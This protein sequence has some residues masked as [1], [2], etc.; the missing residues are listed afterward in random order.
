MEVSDYLVKLKDSGRAYSTILT[1]K[2]A[3]CNTLLHTTGRNYSTN[4]TLQSLIKSFKNS[5]P[6]NV[7]KSPDWNFHIVL[8]AL[9]K[10]PFE[11][12]TDCDIKYLTMK[13]LF[14]VAWASAARISELHALSTKPGHFLLDTENKYVDLIADVNFIAKTQLAS[15]PPRKYR[16]MAIKQLVGGRDR[17]CILCP[18]RA[19]RLYRKRTENKRTNSGRLFVCT[20]T[21]QSK[22]M[23]ISSLS[24]WI[25]RTIRFAYELTKPHELHDVHKITPHEIR[26]ISTSLAVAKHVPIKDIMKTAYWKSE[27]TFTSH[28]MKNLA[29]Y[30]KEIQTTNTVA[31]GVS[32]QI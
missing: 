9:R 24:Y 28:Y 17:D 19:L 30:N 12:L 5:I 13:T 7:C 26:A 14:L 1:H 2:S 6:R 22:D 29:K 23:S 31:A 15:E 21:K 32:L 3:I 18:V 25:K 20:A 16:I 8:N 11:P 4:S 27:S 10:E